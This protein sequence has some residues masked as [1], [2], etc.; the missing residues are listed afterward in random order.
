MQSIIDKYILELNVALESYDLEQY[1]YEEAKDEKYGLYDGN[2]DNRLRLAFALLFYTSISDERIENLV[3]MLFKEELMDRKTNSWQGIGTNLEILTVLL[4]SHTKS[5]DK[6]LFE[7]AKNANFDCHC[8]YNPDDIN[9]PRKLSECDIDFCLCYALELGE[10]ENAAQILN[11][12]KCQQT[13]WNKRNLN[14]LRNREKDLGNSEGELDALEKLVSLA[15]ESNDNWELCSSLKKYL[16]KLN[17]MSYY[18]K[19]W[20]IM[21][22]LI[23]KTKDDYFQCGLG[24]FVLECAVDLVIAE[25]LNPK[26]PQ[27]WDWFTPLMKTTKNLHL[28]LCEK[29]IIAAKQMDNPKLI[30]AFEQILKREKARCRL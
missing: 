11:D 21:D 3:R 14:Q 16:E 22:E 13:E 7:Q 12:W 28:N 25:P 15:Y 19:S 23:E 10:K 26:A 27:L 8:G 24:R 1:K 5:N 2:Y 18:D 9:Y 20:Y 4:K 29:A 6:I 17:S 30:K